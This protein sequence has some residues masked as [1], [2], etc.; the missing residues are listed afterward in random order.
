MAQ[1]RV[2]SIEGLRAL[3]IASVVAYHLEV[4]WLPSGHMGVVMFLVLT[5]YLVT[6]SLLREF[7]RTG[8]VN[9]LAFW[10][11][12]IKRL[13]PPL[14]AMVAVTCAVCVV[15]NHVAL[16]KM[17]PDILPSLLFFDNWNYIASGLSYFD[18]IG[19]VSPLTHLWY[20]GV[21]MQLC[22]LWPLVAL[23]CLKASRNN[24]NLLLGVALG[25]AAVSAVLMAVL[26]VPG[27]D[28]SRVYYGCDTRA[29]SVLLGAALAIMWPLGYMP[30]MGRDL[31]VSYAGHRR[32][33]DEHDPRGFV[34]RPVFVPSK[35]AEASG[36]VG[37]AGLV[38]IM[39]AVPT[40]SMFFYYGGMVLASLLSCL[41]LV[42]LLSRGSIL[43]R[44]FSCA[45]LQ[46][47]GSRSYALYLWH[48]P[49]VVLLDA[50]GYAP[51]WLK[52]VAAAVSLALAELAWRFVE[53][54][55]GD[56]D[57]MAYI[58]QVGVSFF[59]RTPQVAGTAACAVVL[60]VGVVGCIAVPETTL[61][62][63]D[64]ISSTGEAVDKARDLSAE[65]AAKAAA[66]SL[67]SAT[68]SDGAGGTSAQQAGASGADGT[69]AQAEA[70]GDATQAGAPALGEQPAGSTQPAGELSLPEG[71]MSFALRQ[72][73][74]DNALGVYSP[75]LIGDSVPPEDGFSTVFP[76]GYE[77]A[78]VGRMP[79]QA[80][81]VFAD[82]VAQGVVGKTVV[83]ACF[84]NTTPDVEGLE[85]M[86]AGVPQGTHVFLVGT[87]NPDGFQDDANANL[88]Q[89]ADAHDNVHYVDWPA[90]AAGHES[91][92]F[93]DDQTHLRP[94][95]EQAYLDM[96]ARAIAPVVVANGGEVVALG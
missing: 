80:Y 12:R 74:D 76:D 79:A 51:W 25:L 87:K 69:T 2:K 44:A 73:A 49:V 78:Y 32:I 41:V 55:L 61:V 52:L 27:A 18:K 16:T 6:N 36:F 37:L 64:A 67:A 38:I 42:S 10:G 17:R 39:V 92:Y 45:P 15:F 24:K 77:D 59:T 84:T 35:F 57:L 70:G 14:A 56:K 4:G 85:G 96:I 62:P 50:D 82:Y 94:E 13:W 71:V 53:K 83:F 81:S 5:G 8:E 29:F 72:S 34:E 93:W 88:M 19:G 60:L 54:P 91:E 30:A 20:L 65:K 47:L 89:V 22:L 21:D 1:A 40:S 46:W 63:K 43:A 75:I 28:P 95:G 23:G 58:R 3:A 90:T 66:S 31:L 7:D 33:R 9:L 86:V 11:R 68:A 26:Y 48:Y